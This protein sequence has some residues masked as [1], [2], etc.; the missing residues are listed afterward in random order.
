MATEKSPPPSMLTKLKP[1]QFLT[2]VMGEIVEIST[3]DKK[4]TEKPV[5]DYNEHEAIKFVRTA[6]RLLY[7]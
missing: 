6:L 1:G 5:Y 2:P 3:D 4:T 7:E